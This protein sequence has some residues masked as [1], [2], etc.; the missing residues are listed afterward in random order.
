MTLVFQS[1]YTENEDRAMKQ[2]QTNVLYILY[3]I[4]QTAYKSSELKLDDKE[5]VTRYIEKKVSL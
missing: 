5:N 4:A 2:P 3:L 1:N